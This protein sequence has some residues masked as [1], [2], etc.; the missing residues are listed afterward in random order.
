MRIRLR[1]LALV[2]GSIAVIVGLFANDPSRGASAVAWLQ[3]Q[4]LPLLAVALAFYLGKAFHDYPEG[5]LQNTLRKG[6]EHPLGA[7]IIYLARVIMFAA[8]LWAFMAPARAMEPPAR[9]LQY[10]PTL[11]AEIT[12][13]WPEI[14]LRAY[15]AGLIEHESCIS[16]THSR[17]WSPTSRLKSA[18]EEGAGLGQL[19]R[20]Y[21]ADGSL[22]FDALAE[23]R[24]AHPA[25]RGLDWGNIYSEPGLQMRALV[26]KVRAD[27]T[28]MSGNLSPGA[29]LAFADAAYNG[30]RAGVGAER[31]ACAMTTGCDPGQWFGNVELT[32]LKSRV[33]LYGGRSACDINRHH[34][35]DVLRVRAPKYEGLV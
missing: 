21:R 10:L 4:T 12:A 20:A 35:S 34:V 9:A 18:R 27:Y 11:S 15:P 2:G 1:H 32:C 13:Q 16:L 23:M 8:V 6:N 22:R 7:A 31:R 24:A 25:L 29:R 17:C 30:G 19:T 3:A 33:A 14:P 28:A 26:L 5:D